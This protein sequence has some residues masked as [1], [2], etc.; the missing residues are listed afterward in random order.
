MATPR[1]T[2]FLP[3]RYPETWMRKL[4]KSASRDYEESK[5]IVGHIIHADYGS[6]ILLEVFGKPRQLFPIFL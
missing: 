4:H 1:A 2:S 3:L 6:L 5:F